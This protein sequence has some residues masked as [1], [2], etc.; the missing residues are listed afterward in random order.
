MT[1]PEHGY[2]GKN[3]WREKPA[4]I[5]EALDLMLQLAET[6]NSQRERQERAKPQAERSAS[7]GA[8][9]ALPATA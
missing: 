5:Q 8:A 4:V 3:C 6:K 7:H 2:T 1:W 9:P